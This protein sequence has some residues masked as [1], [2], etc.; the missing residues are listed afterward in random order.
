VV[1]TPKVGQVWERRN[2]TRFKIDH[3]TPGYAHYW[4]ELGS[5]PQFRSIR[6]NLLIKNYKLVS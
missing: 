5:R 1:V 2:G 3:F 4:L 6:L